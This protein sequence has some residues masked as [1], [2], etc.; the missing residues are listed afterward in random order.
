M[1]KHGD[2]IWPSRLIPAFL[3]IATLLFLWWVAQSGDSTTAS[4]PITISASV[5]ID[6]LKDATVASTPLTQ[7][8]LSVESAVGQGE[9]LPTEHPLDPVLAL[10]R[11]S[12]SY[13]KRMSETMS[14]RSSNA[15]G[16]MAV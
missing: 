4:P 3:L 8:A 16:S 5:P 13:L 10:A 7:D 11:S 1:V 14:A 15:N 12:L 2:R 6:G 9:T